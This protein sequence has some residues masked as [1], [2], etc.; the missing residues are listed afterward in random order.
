MNIPCFE[1]LK[2]KVILKDS[3]TRKST[4]VMSGESTK[5][6][7]EQKILKEGIIRKK[8]PWFHYNTR[9]LVLYNTNKLEYLE[10]KKNIVKVNSN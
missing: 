3:D 4:S 9:R 6:K 5:E 2:L 7:N 1:K 8:S 10:P